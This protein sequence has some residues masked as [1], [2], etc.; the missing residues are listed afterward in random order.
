[1]CN[2]ISPLAV[3]CI[4]YVLIF[5]QLNN[6]EEI[7]DS[8]I[9]AELKARFSEMIEVHPLRKEDAFGILRNQTCISI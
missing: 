8:G 2:L 3:W 1:M 7:D 9:F 6:L 5:E 4:L